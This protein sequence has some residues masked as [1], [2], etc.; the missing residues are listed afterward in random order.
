M[1][2]KEVGGPSRTRVYELRRK[3]LSGP[4][5]AKVLG[6]SHQAVYQHLKELRAK[7]VLK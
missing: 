4:A 7:G 5:I 2:T 1:A 3:G 6:I